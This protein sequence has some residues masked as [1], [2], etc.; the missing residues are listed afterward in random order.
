MIDVYPV[1][2]EAIEQETKEVM[3]TMETFD[4]HA[5]SV[6]IKTVV[7]PANINELVAAMRRAVVMLEL[8]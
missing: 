4:Q 2:I 5:A 6:E 7:G 8:K 3:F 1:K